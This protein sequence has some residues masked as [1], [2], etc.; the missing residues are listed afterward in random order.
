MVWGSTHL[1][2]GNEHSEK[3]ARDFSDKGLYY[4]DSDDGTRYGVSTLHEYYTKLSM[5]LR[6]LK[7]SALPEHIRKMLKD[8][9]MEI[10][11]FSSM[12]KVFVK[13]AYK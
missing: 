2:K 4:F 9:I 8:N 6:P 1:F 12:D 10:E 13:H 5:P 11:D 7:Y 3:I